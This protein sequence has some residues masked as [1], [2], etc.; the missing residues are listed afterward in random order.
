MTTAEAPTF[1]SAFGAAASDR[2]PTAAENPPNSK[3]VP[4]ATNA[5][6]AAAATRNDFIC[7]SPEV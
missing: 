4:T 1:N 6:K 2:T 5:H 7:V 3:K